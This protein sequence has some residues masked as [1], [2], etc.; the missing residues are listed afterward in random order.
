MFL[1]NSVMMRSV[2]QVKTPEKI[3]IFHVMALVDE[4]QTLIF[5]Q[6]CSVCS[7]QAIV[8]QTPWYEMNQF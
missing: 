8:S 3:G 7:K 6:N 4:K 2:Q 5:V 1:M